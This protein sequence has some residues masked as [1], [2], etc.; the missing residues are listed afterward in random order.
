MPTFA[1]IA[2]SSR[3]ERV[4][5]TLEAASEQV[6]LG[7]LA[8]RGL[9]PIRVSALSSGGSRRGSVG[10]RRLAAAYQQLGDLLHAGVPLLRALRLLARSRSSPALAKVMGEVADDV[11]DG[12]RLADAMA[13]RSA[14]FPQIQVA[15]VRAGE[16]GGFLDQVFLRMAEFLGHQADLRA[17]VI[18]SLVYPLILLVVGVGIVVAALVF[19]VPRFRD[20]YKDM[21]LP[22]PTRIVM[23][24]SDL[25]TAHGWAVL[26]A[27]VAA[28]IAA[29]WAIRR[30]QVRRAAAI[31]QLR[32][33]QLGPLVRQLA[34]A[35][36]CRVLGTM[37]R[38][39]I[40]MLQAM[41][42]SRDAAGHPLM[43]EAIDAAT[44]AV[45]SGEQLAEPLRASGLFDDDVVEMISVGE[46]ANNLDTVLVSV[47]ETIERRVDRLLAIALRL[48]EPLLLL[49]LAGVVMFI[50]LAL[51]VPMM[52]LSAGMR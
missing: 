30:P 39:G 40:P 33:P 21:A 8:T 16:R 49:A 48:L 4:S 27:V 5:G 41:R 50:F 35:R 17:K 25:V 14:T 6:V 20:F 45:R 44:E 47:A 52:K 11:A 9:A 29:A 15:M 43:E 32:L 7:E 22:L 3:G 38:N 23:G 51:V 18:G 1:Y 31:A 26:A 46:S 19:F 42:I 34:V 36:F 12:Q 10:I 24:A 37:L 28:A 2:R 13:R